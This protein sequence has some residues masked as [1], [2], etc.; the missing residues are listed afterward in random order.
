MVTRLALGFWLVVL[1]AG[2][3]GQCA[4]DYDCVPLG[5]GLIC[6]ASRSCVPARADAGVDGGTGSV[7]DA[8]LP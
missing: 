5:R 2:C 3:S 6:D 4:D 8:G 7:P 1:L